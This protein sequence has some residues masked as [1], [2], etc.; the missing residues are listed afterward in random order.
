MVVIIDMAFRHSRNEG[1]CNHLF[2]C[3]QVSCT[4]QSVSSF[5]AAAAAAAT[6]FAVL[7]AECTY[8]AQFRILRFTFKGSY[9]SLTRVD[10]LQSSYICKLLQ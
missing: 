8:L 1:N 10:P 3:C 9:S 5:A 4:S 2:I 7:P 6:D